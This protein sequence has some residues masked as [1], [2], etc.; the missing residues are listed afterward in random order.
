MD[1]KDLSPDLQAALDEIGI[2]MDM[3]P[4]EMS[5]RTQEF[6]DRAK[7][8]PDMERARLS[9]KM[10]QA[11][12]L[13]DLD[14]RDLAFLMKVDESFDF[15]EMEPYAR[16]QVTEAALRMF[17]EKCYADAARSCNNDVDEVSFKMGLMG[18]IIYGIEITEQRHA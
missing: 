17:I 5:A 11:L 18:G 1:N 6:T 15:A 13:T 4:E 10:E 14:K 3:S 9:E 12:G 7:N 2:S 16:V 8:L